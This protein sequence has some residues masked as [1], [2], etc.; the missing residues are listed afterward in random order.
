MH[1][2]FYFQN[3][4]TFFPPKEEN[5]VYVFSLPLAEDGYLTGVDVTDIGLYNFLSASTATALT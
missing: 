3:F 2:G 4:S 1:L 5:G